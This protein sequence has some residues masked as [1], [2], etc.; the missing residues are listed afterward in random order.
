MSDSGPA[1]SYDFIRLKTKPTAQL[2]YSF[3][4]ATASTAAKP[5]LIVF[6]NGLGLPQ[7]G[8]ALTIAK[9]R[10]YSPQSL[11]AILTYDR[12]GQGQSIDRDP[13][14]EGATDPSHAHDCMS[15][16]RDMRQLTT[17]I[18]RDRMNVEESDTLR[19]VLVGN[20]LGCSLIRLYAHEYPGT[21]S[22]IVFLDSTLTDTD[23]VSIFP[24]PD[25]ES[26]DPV[27]PPGVT[28]ESLRDAR[29]MIRQR[30]HPDIGSQEGLSR[31][32]LFQ[33]LPR[34]DLPLLYRDG[35]KGPYITVLGH[36]FG[37]FAERT[38]IDLGIPVAVIQAYMNPYWNRYNQGLA[39]LTASGRS[40]G[41]LQVPGAGHFIQADNPEFVAERVREMLQRLEVE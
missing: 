33:L 23:F 4:P 17:Q 14:D 32:N 3:S 30:F 10:E 41:P 5:T 24:D 38:E 21:V 28:A 11:P 22:G 13:A 2:C 35:E 36:D 20:S 7:V 1:T 29:E 19:L 15:A 8:W 40:K 16:V 37:A 18:L 34:A 27:L 39:K 26:F 12:F 6:V 9:L 31:R 25:A